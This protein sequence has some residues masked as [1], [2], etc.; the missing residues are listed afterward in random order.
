[1]LWETITSHLEI[2]DTT[3][4]KY[5]LLSR[6]SCS[7]PVEYIVEAQSDMSILFVQVTAMSW[8]ALRY[9]GNAARSADYHPER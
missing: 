3:T 4:L 8:A 5:S 1:M 6:A 2:L 7:L 9:K